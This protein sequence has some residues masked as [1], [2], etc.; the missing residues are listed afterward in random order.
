MTAARGKDDD[1]KKEESG[2]IQHVANEV[3]IELLE[4]DITIVAGGCGEGV[5]V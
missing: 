3:L 5:L 4:I 2:A 1:R